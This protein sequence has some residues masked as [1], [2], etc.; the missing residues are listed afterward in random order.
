MYIILS[1]INICCDDRSAL[2]R[3]QNSDQIHNNFSVALRD[4][5]LRAM[6]MEQKKNNQM[7]DLG[8]MRVGKTTILDDSGLSIQ[9]TAKPSNLCTSA[10][11]KTSLGDV[12]HL[13]LELVVT[14]ILMPERIAA[15]T[16]HA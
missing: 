1:S 6:I 9:V 8:E 10:Q 2:L 13:P 16:E 5:C 12:H 7:C 3:V 4:N 14:V 11:L 15:A